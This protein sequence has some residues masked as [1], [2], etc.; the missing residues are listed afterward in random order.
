MSSPQFRKPK[1]KFQLH[2]EH[3]I[4]SQLKD[5]TPSQL[6]R[7][8][9]IIA[10]LLP[11]SFDD[12]KKYQ[13]EFSNI[14]EKIGA[15][16]GDN[17]RNQIKKSSMIPEIED[18]AKSS[19]KKSLETMFPFLASFLRGL[20]GKFMDKDERIEIQILEVNGKPFQEAIA[21]NLGLNLC[22]LRFWPL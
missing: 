12:M 6:F 21:F 7:L 5:M 11:L 22:S 16:L 19:A 10:N 14:I 1:Q 18:L 4:S 17:I 8:F 15:A 2:F 9:F 3:D 20:G 13:S